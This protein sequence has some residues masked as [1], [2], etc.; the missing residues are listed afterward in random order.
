MASSESYFDIKSKIIFVIAG[1][2]IP[3]VLFA[4][5]YQSGQRF[6]S[7]EIP[8]V[9]SIMQLRVDL[10]STH[11]LI[12]EYVEGHQKISKN[13]VT[14][15][16]RKVKADAGA[17]HYGYVQMGDIS[18]LVTSSQ[19][20]QR[21][22]DE[23]KRAT[24]QLIEYLLEYKDELHLL[25]VD[26]VTHD[27]YFISAEWAAAELDEEIHKQFS[28]SLSQQPTLFAALLLIWLLMLLLML[29]LLRKSRIAHAVEF[30]RNLKLAQALEHSGSSIIITDID[31]NIEYVNSAFCNLTGYERDDV[32]GKKTSILNSGQQSSSFYQQL[33]Q[34]ISI[35]NVW[36]SELVNRHK[37]GSTCP[38]VMSIAPI[39][40]QHNQITHYIASQEDMSEFEALEEKLYKSQK[41]ET[42]GILAGGIAHDFNNALTAIKA[43]AQMLERKAEDRTGV[44]KRASA[45][46]QVCDVA[47]RHISQLLKFVRNEDLK[48][49]P[50]NLNACMGT[51]CEIAS[52][53]ADKATIRIELSEQEL[54]VCWNDVQAQQIMINLINNAMHAVQGVASPW[55]KVSVSK[56]ETTDSFAQKFPLMNDNYYACISVKDN[57]YGIPE[58][59]LDTI[60][61]V[62][63]T[64]K[65]EGEGTG[66]G[67]SMAHGAITKVGGVMEVA[68]RVNE[69]T[70]FRIY[71]PLCTAP[72]NSEL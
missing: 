17:I 71:L 47:A 3:L 19:H 14:D 10:T 35:G 66:L 37:D 39:T 32:I 60:F 59:K 54:C 33:W 9:D 30:A 5:A 20:L 55:V 4:W 51:A 13:D 23:M 40:N 11:S 21:E 65:A 28:D 15:L 49:T 64:T 69:G 1:V 8:L 34:T 31:A 16:I 53:G 57:G 26:D 24:D 46:N 67:L 2:L 62:F 27:K 72:D 36:H 25:V 48:L 63:F 44:L 45:I 58:D 43:N 41:L 7:Q 22:F 29:N 61:E 56:F 52:M 18:S 68:S 38:I 70:E 12:H 50:I 42:A 6:L